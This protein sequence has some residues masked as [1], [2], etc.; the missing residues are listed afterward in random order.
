M[1]LKDGHRCTDSGDRINED[2]VYGRASARVYHIDTDR[3]R[4]VWVPYC[5]V[6]SVN[7]GEL[8][9]KR[10]SLAFILG[11]DPRTDEPVAIDSVRYPKVC[12]ACLAKRNLQRLA[13]SGI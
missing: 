3:E 9:G 10:S 5:G 13:E 7:A 2:Y 1:I 8:D 12:K 6:R 4:M 11:E